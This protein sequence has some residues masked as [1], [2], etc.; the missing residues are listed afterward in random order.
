MLSAPHKIRHELIETMMAALLAQFLR[1]RRVD[2][3]IVG[4]RMSMMMR[5]SGVVAVGVPCALSTV[6][7]CAVVDGRAKRTFKFGADT[8]RTGARVLVSAM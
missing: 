2:V 1:H 3:V 5:R 4:G 6:Q 7:R 8:R